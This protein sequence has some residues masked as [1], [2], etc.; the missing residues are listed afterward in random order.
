MHQPKAAIY[1]RVSTDKQFD[2]GGSLDT[3]EKSCCAWC[4]R[5]E[6]EVFDIYKEVES[7]GNLNRDQFQRLYADAE[8][9][10]FEAVVVTKIDRLSRSMR[11]Y[12][13]KIIDFE[14]FN[15]RIAAVDQPAFSTAGA[16]GNFLRNI[17]LAAAE[18]EREMIRQRTSEGMRAKIA[19]GEWHGGPVPLGYENNK[20]EKRLKVNENEAD[21][22]RRIY[23]EYNSGKSSKEIT[24]QLNAEGLRTKKGN[25]FSAQAV[26]RCY[27]IL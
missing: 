24:N 21:L 6:H 22:V 15:V 4:E 1:C 16:T 11:D 9:G 20:V 26:L 7:G 8:A 27:K 10:K 13:S 12:Y 5:N 14:K 19:K 17:L 18:F 3:Q 23:T 2:K 25:I